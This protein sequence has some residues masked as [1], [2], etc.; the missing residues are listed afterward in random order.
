MK[1][2]ALRNTSEASRRTFRG[3]VALATLLAMLG[4]VL[5]GAAHAQTITEFPISSGNGPGSITSGPDGNLWFTAGPAGSIGRITPDGVVTEFPVPTP[6]V[7]P[8]AIVAGPD[9]N[10]W[11]TEQFIHTFG[12]KIGRITTAGEITEFPTAGDGYPL[13]IA[14]GPDGNHLVHRS[15][16]H[17]RPD[18]ALRRHHGR[19]PG[20]C[21]RRRKQHRQ[22]PGRQPLV[23]GHLSNTI[24]RITPAGVVS[25]FPVPT[26]HVGPNQITAGADGNLWFTEDAG[27]IG[28]ITTAG[29]VTEFPVPTPNS[30]T[31]GIT[32]G[33]DGNVWFT[34][35]SAGFSSPGADGR[36]IGKITPAGDVTE[37]ELLTAAS[38]PSGITTGPDGNLWVT[39]LSAG[40]IARVD[41]DGPCST[42]G[43]T[44]CLRG[45]RFQVRAHWEI[46]SKGLSGDGSAV[47]LSA[48]SGYF[49]FFDAG[50][51]ELIVKVLDA[52][53]AENARF[54][55]FA[56]GLT[57][58]G[59]TLTVTDS[60]TLQSKTYTNTAG[61]AF[62]PIQDTSAFSTCP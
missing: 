45:G 56:G 11:F 18:H 19:F 31:N 36:K 38:G 42:H 39:E 22:G 17:D 51:V 30:F 1:G 35:Y 58:V 34:E 61:V 62:Q 9:G 60:Q 33:P 55:V 12:G 3:R 6:D 8:A 28:R 54:W 50:N 41:P 46:P 16:R 14:A 24:G 53:S 7:V 47:A 20:R 10:L 44:L 32:V 5:A 29:V 15:S 52:C 37:I 43:T 25:T 13:G 40:K 4:A 21:R 57:N 49:W 48:D 27:G 23:H 2:E 59:V 26:A